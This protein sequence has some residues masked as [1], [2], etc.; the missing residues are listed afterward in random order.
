MGL[1]SELLIR[2]YH[3]SQDRLTYR[4]RYIFRGGE[5]GPTQSVQPGDGMEY[6]RRAASPV[7][8]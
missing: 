7:R 4:V 8:R 6:R 3:E 2:I 5:M 1:I